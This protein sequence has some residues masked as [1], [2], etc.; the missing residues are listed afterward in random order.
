MSATVKFEAVSNREDWNDQV[1]VYVN[2]A[3]IDLTGAVVVLAVKDPRTRLQVLI[4]QTADGSITIP[5]LGII[6][7][8]FPVEQM[9]GLEASKRYEMFCTAVINGKTSQLFTGEVPIYDGGVP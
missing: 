6:E 3:L 1:H 2:D 5:A 9:R 4:A 7:F 8:S